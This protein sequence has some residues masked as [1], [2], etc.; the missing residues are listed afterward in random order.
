MVGNLLIACAL[1]ISGAG[2][3]QITSIDHRTTAQQSQSTTVTAPALPLLA[4]P[5]PDP[6]AEAEPGPG[7]AP[8]R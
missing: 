8:G 3:A 7:T 1:A 2:M 6:Q 4:V 5:G